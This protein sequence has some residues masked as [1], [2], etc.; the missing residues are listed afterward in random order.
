MYSG[1]CACNFESI[2]LVKISLNSE[3]TINLL[4]NLR[5]DF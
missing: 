5:V 4:A 3:E 1:W 2:E